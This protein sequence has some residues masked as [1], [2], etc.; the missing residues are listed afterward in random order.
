MTGDLAEAQLAELLHLPPV[1]ERREPDDPGQQGGP[2][3]AVVGAAFALIGVLLWL[4]RPDA[5]LTWTA[6][7]L[8]GLG[9][10]QVVAG[11]LLTEQSRRNGS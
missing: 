10:A 1:R 2:L 9:A 7:A 4:L 8:I 6:V 5:T 3:L 11:I